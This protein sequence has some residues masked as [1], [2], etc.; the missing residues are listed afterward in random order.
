MGLIGFI[1]FLGF[2]GFIGFMGFIGFI[3]FI[4][5]RVSPDKILHSDAGHPTAGK[6]R[7]AHASEHPRT[8]SESAPR[9]WGLGV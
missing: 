5:F 6:A 2:I 3:G 7:S 8:R 4:G 9:V 1:G